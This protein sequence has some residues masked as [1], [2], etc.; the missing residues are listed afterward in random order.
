MVKYSKGLSFNAL[1]NYK[2]GNIASFALG[3]FYIIFPWLSS[4]VLNETMAIFGLMFLTVSIMRAKPSNTVIGGLFQAFI[5]VIYLFA[6]AGLVNM[7]VLWFMTI[8]L[9]FVFFIFELGFVK[10][11]PVSKKADVFQVV[12]FT[13][14]AFGLIIS[15]AGYSTLFVI[16]WQNWLIALNYVA[17]LLFSLMSALQLAG[18]NIG[19][20][21]TNTWLTVFA[22]AAIVTSV[23]GVYQGSLFQWTR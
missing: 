11:G 23:V 4:G 15:M 22:V 12:P 7:T 18:W 13:I 21:S 19:G 16:D 17:V 3:I 5:G 1:L 8:G 14:L 9:A 20:K 2:N 10:F 6:L